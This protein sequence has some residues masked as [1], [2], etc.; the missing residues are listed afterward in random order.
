MLTSFQIDRFR[1]FRRLTLPGLGQVNLVVG[2]NNTGKTILLEALR[3]HAARG[4]A[5]VVKETLLDRDEFDRMPRVSRAML[6]RSLRFESLFH[7]RSVDEPDARILLGPLESPSESLVLK[8]VRLSWR[9]GERPDSGDWERV[10]PMTTE[11]APGLEP[12]QALG[13]AVSY[14]GASERL[15]PP[16]AVPDF[17]I[18]LQMFVADAN[19][20]EETSAFIPAAGLSPGV[21]STW[22]DTV[23]LTDAEERVSE[24]L[25]IVAPV[26][27]ISLVDRPGAD[28]RRMVM[29]KL[30][31]ESQPVP[32]RSLG[33]GVRKMFSFALGLE[34]SRETRIL[35]IDEIENGI[36]YTAHEDLWRFLMTAALRAGVQV[37][38]TTHSW[39]CV[40]GFQAALGAHPDLSATAIR[41]YRGDQEIDAVVLDREEIAVATR[42][43]VDFR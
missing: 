9:P 31:G 42:D 5:A 39:D 8:P 18:P 27:R 11:N 32:L 17:F 1:I 26:Q 28:G 19:R 29:V 21:I 10:T 4:N 38:A 43:Q 12:N 13:L 14:G 40:M 16:E 2:R 41:L 20:R 30:D 33:D 22:W 37:F 35:L 15:I 6:G 36:H 23:T 7:K 24:C 25:R 34:A 3:L